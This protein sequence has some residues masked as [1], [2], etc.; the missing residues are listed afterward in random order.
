[1]KSEIAMKR[2][3]VL[4]LSLILPSLTCAQEAAKFSGPLAEMMAGKRVLLVSAHPDDEGLFA[5]LLAEVCRFNG[6]TCHMVVAADAKSPGCIVPLKM[7]DLE[8][9]SSMRRQEVAA[10]A[11][12][13]NASHEFYGWRDVLSPWND[14]G[15]DRNIHEWAQDMGGRNKLVK[16]ISETL[17]KFKPDYLLGFDPRHGTSC[18]PNHRAIVLLAIEAVK[19]LPTEER[20]DVWLESDFAVPT[21]APPGLAPIIDG[22]GIVRWPNDNVATTWYDSNFKLPNGRTTWDYLVD[23]LRLNST[24]FPDVATGKV[25]PS[26]TPEHRRVPFVKLADINPTQRGMCESFTPEFTRSF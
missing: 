15:L 23:V 4:A 21:T 16:R 26:P 18:H 22:F 11:A 25:T 10:S 14:A 13:L 19:Q 5:P 17:E 3:L 20:P 24:Q 12:N 7:H 2:I 6:A 9:C 8:K 1:M